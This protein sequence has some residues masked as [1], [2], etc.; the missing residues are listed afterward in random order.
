M[1]ACVWNTNKFVAAATFL[2]VVIDLCVR[3]DI[4]TVCFIFVKL[5]IN[6]PIVYVY[7]EIQP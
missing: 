6:Q 1:Y 5:K 3:R 7:V 4:Q 2:H